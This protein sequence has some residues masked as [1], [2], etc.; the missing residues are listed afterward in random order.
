[1]E[2]APEILSQT[3]Y[4]VIIWD[5]AVGWTPSVSDARECSIEVDRYKFYRPVRH[6]FNPS[7]ITVSCAGM[8]A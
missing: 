1:L 7:V 5:T 3:V 2:N 8:A 4:R 6:V